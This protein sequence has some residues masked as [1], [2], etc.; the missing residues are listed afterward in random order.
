MQKQVLIVKPTYKTL[1]LYIMT[2]GQILFFKNMEYIFQKVVAILKS[3]IPLENECKDM[4]RQGSNVNW[5][6]SCTIP[7]LAV[8]KKKCTIECYILN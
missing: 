4:G 6:I 5:T 7:E 2:V 3:T 8:M 1:G